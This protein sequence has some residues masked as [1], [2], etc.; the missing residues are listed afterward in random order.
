M[1]ELVRSHL[2]DSAEKRS[3]CPGG[4][5]SRDSSAERSIEMDGAQVQ[6]AV[7]WGEFATQAAYPYGA[8]VDSITAAPDGRSITVFLSGLQA[9]CAG[10]FPPAPVPT[11]DRT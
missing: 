3:P 5:V 6:A 9:S 4:H 10:S 7:V 8:A 11:T 1:R 2:H